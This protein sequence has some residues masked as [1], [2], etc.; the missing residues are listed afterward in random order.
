M[1]RRPSLRF[2]ALLAVL[3]F[4]VPLAAGAGCCADCLFSV[5]PDCCPPACCAC[6]GHGPSVAASSAWASLRPVAVARMQVPPAVSLLS[7]HT[8][9]VFHVPKPSPA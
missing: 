2:L 5:S 7:S 4:L 3:A 9:D 1:G 6:C 8:R